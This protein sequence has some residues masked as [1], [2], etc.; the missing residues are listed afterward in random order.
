[1]D[2]ENIF[3]STG[4]K[5]LHHPPVLRDAKYGM[6]RP[7]SL[8]VSPTSR[9]NL[10]CIFCS[11]VNRGRDEELDPKDLKLLVVKL[12]TSGLKTVE[13]TGGGDPTMYKPINQMIAYTA[14]YGL[15]QG[16]ITNGLLLK[17]NLSEISLESLRWIRVSMNCL[18]YINK[19]DLPKIPGTLGFSY[20]MNSLTNG[21]TLF[22]LDRHVKKYKPK[23]VRI[24]PN[25][26]A[27]DEEQEKNNERYAREILAW[28]EPYF[29]Q[30][31][32]FAKP[33]NCW[34]CYFKPFINHDGWVYPCSSVVLNLDAEA[35]FHENYRWCHMNDLPEKYLTPMVPFDPI[36][37][38]HC[39]FKNQN[40]LI[41]N[42]KNPDGMEDFI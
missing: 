2:K 27:T 17:K 16:L 26:Q 19:V 13:W 6:G 4:I 31:K 24:I 33:K 32:T 22:N 30:A 7:I 11:N 14:S 38:N 8:Q 37:C 29:Y 42:L 39:V 20:V 9:C 1:M 15:K 23:Y 3:T 12:A 35:Q 5:L 41:E 18:D 36:N 21:S 10:N 28:G 25:C 40:D 34:W